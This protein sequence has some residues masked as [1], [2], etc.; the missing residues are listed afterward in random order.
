MGIK[1]GSPNGITIVGGRPMHRAV[2]AT[3][4]P[5][6]VEQ[7]L[8]IAALDPVFR[9]QVARDPISAAAAKGIRLDPVEAALLQSMPAQR[10]AAM[11]GERGERCAGGERE[12]V[13]CVELG[14]RG[15]ILGVDEG[16]HAAGGDD[17]CG[18]VVGQA[19]D[20]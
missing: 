4:L 17:A 6:G 16:A 2:Q 3:E 19:A 10:L 8:T 11:T 1:A 13:A 12:Q 7:V 9:A 15:E 5:Q 18:G 14:A 20:H